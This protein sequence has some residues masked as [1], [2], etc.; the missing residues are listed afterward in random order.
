MHIIFKKINSNHRWVVQSTGAEA[1]P[2]GGV[3]FYN[4]DTPFSR[5]GYYLYAWD[6]VSIF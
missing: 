3:L 2:L 1:L 4:K 5:V 6:T